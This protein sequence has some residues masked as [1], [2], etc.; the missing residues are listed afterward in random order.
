M[1][2]NQ[3]IKVWFNT[4]MRK[5]VSFIEKKQIHLYLTDRTYDALTRASNE[6]GCTRTWLVRHALQYYLQKKG[7]YTK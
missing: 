2:H 1:I 3:C 4:V 7:Y 6:I 5:G